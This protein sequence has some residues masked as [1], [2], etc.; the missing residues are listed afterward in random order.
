MNDGNRIPLS[1]TIR[2]PRCLARSPKEDRPTF[3]AQEV[4][5]HPH[6]S[7]VALYCHSSKC[8]YAD[9]LTASTPDHRSS[10][11]VVIRWKR[12][13]LTIAV[14]VF[15]NLAFAWWAIVATTYLIRR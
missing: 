7:M 14:L 8:G 1:T 5:T 11:D 15:T 10:M 3:L 6:L 9:V 4:L 13:R 2:C 12:S